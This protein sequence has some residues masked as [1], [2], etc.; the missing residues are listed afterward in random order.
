MT[1]EPKSILLLVFVVSFA[2]MI[3]RFLPY[4]SKTI[5]KLPQSIKDKLELLPVAALG[6]LI[7]PFAILDFPNV[8]YAGLCGVAAA[9]LLGYLKQNMIVS[10]IA[11]IIITYGILII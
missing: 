6:A 9:F 2:T 7:F 5:N 3:P 10:I 11:S 4:F 1:T 8:W